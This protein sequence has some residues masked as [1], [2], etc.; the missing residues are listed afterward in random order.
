MTTTESRPVWER[1][2][3]DTVRWGLKRWLLF[4]NL[5]VLVYGGLPWL[6]PIAHAAGYRTLGNLLF[7]L[8][9]PLC[10]QK[11]SQSFFLNGYQVAV[12]QREAIMYG[13]RFAGGLLFALFRHQ[14][15]AMPVRLGALLLL[16][17][18]IDG[19]SQLI[20]DL[21]G[22]TLLRGTNDDIGS[23]NFWMRM[24]TGL[25]FAIAVLLVVYPRLERDLRQAQIAA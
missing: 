14:V 9:T 16:P 2:I 12:C 1:R 11:P 8:Y 7:A 21:L 17:M 22:G 23:F 20:D 5:V 4:A 10:H 15:R 19:G 18:L 13:A 25:L 24:A 6:S 3:N